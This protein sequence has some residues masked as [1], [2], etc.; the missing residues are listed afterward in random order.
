MASRQRDILDT[1]VAAMPPGRDFPV[2][3]LYNLLPAKGRP[4]YSTFGAYLRRAVRDRR[5]IHPRHGF[6]RRAE[7]ATV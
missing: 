7:D 1:F 6:Y 5:I 3:K 2:G 4:G